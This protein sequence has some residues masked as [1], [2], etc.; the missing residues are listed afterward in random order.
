MNCPNC[1]KEMEK[2]FLQ[3]GNMMTW[4]RKP[5]ILTLYPKK[6]EVMVGRNVMNAVS[7]T[8]YICK[9]CKKIVVDYE[10]SDYEER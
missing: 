2:G 4:V 8:A 1:K 6:G 5:H 9:S 10:E 7:V 3:G